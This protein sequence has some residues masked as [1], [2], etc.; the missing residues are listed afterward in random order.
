ML[1]KILMLL[2][3]VVFASSVSAKVQNNKVQ[4]STD[5]K[6]V[7]AIFEKYA[8]YKK[9]VAENEREEIE[10]RMPTMEE[11]QYNYNQEMLKLEREKVEYEKQIAYD[12]LQE[13]KRRNRLIDSAL[14]GGAGYGIY[15]IGRRH[16]RWW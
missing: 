2:M 9:L 5:N 3:L 11:I 4:N 6:E 8:A 14:I 7:N 12:R 10:R 15:R 16:H 13:E 1:K